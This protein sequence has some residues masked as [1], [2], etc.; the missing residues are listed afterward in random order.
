MNTPLILVAASGLAREALEAVRAQDRYDVVGVVDDDPT[1]AAEVLADVK[2][3]GGL[4]V[5]ADHYDAAVLICA[6]RGATRQAIADRLSLPD[7]RFATVVH[8]SVHVPPSCQIGAGTIV[9]AGCVLTA[10]VTVGRC[11][12]A[13]PHV[14][15][16][17]DDVIDDYA[18]LCAGVTLGGAVRIGPR[19]YLGMSSSVREHVRISSDAVIGMGAVVLH[20]VP[21]GQTWLGIPARPV[22]SSP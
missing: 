21:D 2:V 14:T 22:T 18:T 6:G 8:P 7:E 4:Y 3:L 10:A 17:H 9:L 1:R 12:V 20:D 5:V 13:M 16:T 11:V 15:F 19:S